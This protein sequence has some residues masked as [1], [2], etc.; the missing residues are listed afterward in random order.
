MKDTSAGLRAGLI[1][2]CLLVGMWVLV[3]S[4]V[5][6]IAGISPQE[7]LMRLSQT[8][9]ATQLGFS[10]EAVTFFF[11]VG[12]VSESVFCTAL[13]A[14]LGVVFVKSASHLPFHSVHLKALI[15]GCI[16]YLVV[17]AYGLLFGRSPDV[18]LLLSMLIDSQIFSFLYGSLKKGNKG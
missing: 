8:P 5:D 3:T 1:A 17:P 2:G 12:L 9:R 18:Y 14:V 4:L 16:I 13:G 10:V 6:A 15:F 11:A 7:I